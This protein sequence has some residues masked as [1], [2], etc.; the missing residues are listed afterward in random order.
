[1]DDPG[2][3]SFLSKLVEP[4][5]Q[6]LSSGARGLDF[7]CG[8]GPAASAMLRERGFA[9]ALFDPF[10]APDESVL[11]QGY[12]FI[13]CTEVVEHF[14]R[15]AEEFD[16]LGEL[17]LPGGLLAVMTCFQSGDERFAGWHYRRDPTHVTFYREKTLRFLAK[18]RGWS[19]EIPVKD[20]AIMRRS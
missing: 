1:M 16:R 6:R 20:V 5:A 18:Q 13:I 3:R 19:C 14:H 15:P 2:Y 7:G 8:P 10:F 12:D 11:R 9:V 17:L 4:L